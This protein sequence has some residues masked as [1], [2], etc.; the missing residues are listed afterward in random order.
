MRCV[1]NFSANVITWL[2]YSRKSSGS[3]KKSVSIFNRN[4]FK[5]F[6]NWY[7]WSTVSIC[8]WQEQLI[9]SL[10]NPGSLSTSCKIDD[11]CK[12][13]CI[14]DLYLIMHCVWYTISI[15]FTVIKFS[16]TMHGKISLS[17]ILCIIVHQSTFCCDMVNSSQ[18]ICHLDSTGTFWQKNHQ[19]SVFRT[20][21]IGLATSHCP[22]APMGN[23]SWSINSHIF[24]CKTG[25]TSLATNRWVAS[26]SFIMNFLPR[27]FLSSR[28]NK[29]CFTAGS[30]YTR[31]EIF[32][33]NWMIKIYNL[34]IT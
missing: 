14:G 19:S 27:A 29:N 33:I 21:S 16:N 31:K 24:S 23:D 10:V 28:C 12:Q 7:L 3:L 26:K 17:T 4:T 22:W 20:N 11:F 2:F 15:E 9:C 30:L 32:F 18:K 8:T 13:R 1:I 5:N 34:R 25:T 6:S